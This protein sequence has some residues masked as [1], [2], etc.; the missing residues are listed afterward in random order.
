MFTEKAKDIW[1]DSCIKMS[2][3]LLE[4]WEPDGS[5]RTSSNERELE[6]NLEEFFEAAK[7]T[8]YDKDIQ[9]YVKDPDRRSKPFKNEPL[10][11]KRKTT[12]K[13][14]TQFV[15][16]RNSPSLPNNNDGAVRFANNPLNRVEKVK[17]AL[18]APPDLLSQAEE[19]AQLAEE[20]RKKKSKPLDENQG[21]EIIDDA[22][23]A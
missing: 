14:Y 3:T 8:K 10:S 17:N 18:G 13:D 12:D 23:A 2:K 15:S 19:I 7:C 1:I 4:Y 16:Q 20:R 9:D 5:R 11:N 6:D 21:G 22:T